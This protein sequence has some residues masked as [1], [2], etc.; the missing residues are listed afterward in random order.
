MDPVDREEKRR[1]EQQMN[2][3][4]IF[5]EAKFPFV[6]SDEILNSVF[7]GIDRQVFNANLDGIKLEWCDK[8]KSRAVI[9]YERSTYSTKQTY[10][11]CSKTWFKNRNR[12][13]FVEAILV[14]WDDCN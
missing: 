6:G 12:K 7:D 9:A 1:A 11:R 2:S 14:S 4:E 10:I 5:P 13:Q 8:L 3:R